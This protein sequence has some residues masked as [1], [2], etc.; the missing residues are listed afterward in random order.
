MKMKKAISILLTAGMVLSALSGCGTGNKAAD[1]PADK[2]VAGR[3]SC[4]GGVVGRQ[5]KYGGGRGAD[6]GY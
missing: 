4:T 3:N 6:I 5:R 1:A 2:E